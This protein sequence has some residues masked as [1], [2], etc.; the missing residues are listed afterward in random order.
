MQMVHTLKGGGMMKLNVRQ[1]LQCCNDSDLSPIR[2]RP[3]SQTT[4]CKTYVVLNTTSVVVPTTNHIT[5][6]WN[7]GV[8]IL[9]ILYG[10]GPKEEYNIPR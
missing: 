5:R 10:W 9:F 2:R 3:L 4:K 6:L 7:G 8:L 1:M